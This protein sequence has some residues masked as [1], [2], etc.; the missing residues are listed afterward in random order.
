M[1]HHRGA[2]GAGLLLLLLLCV[3]AASLP[4]PISASSSRHDFVVVGSGSAGS[5]VAGRLAA[6]GHSVLLLEAGRRTQASLGGCDAGGDDRQATDCPYV[7]PPYVPPP[8]TPNT[9]CANPLS[10]FDV[11]LGWMEIITQPRFTSNF[12]WNFSRA[13]PNTSLPALARA[14]GG[15]GIHNAMI[16]VR[17]TETDFGAGSLWDAQGW[18][19]GTVLPFYRRTENN[20]DFPDSNPFHSTRGPVQI[21]SVATQDRAAVSLLF[22]RA[23]LASGHPYNPDF[24]GANRHGV[25]PYQFLIRNGVRDSSAAAFIGRHDGQT[26][27][28]VD[29]AP[30]ATVSRVL[31]AADDNGSRIGGGGGGRDNATAI[32]VE[33]TDANGTTRV[34]QATHEVI[35]SAGALGTP[36][37]LMRS[38]VGNHTDLLQAGVPR[39]VGA[40]LPAVGQGLMDGVYII[41]QF[42]IP[43][44]A[45]DAWERC[46]PFAVDTPQSAFCRNQSRLYDACN[47]SAERHGAYATPGLS[48]G[49]FLQSPYSQDKGPDVQVTFHPWDKFQ[50]NWTRGPAAAREAL[51]T[52]GRGRIVTLE[53][54]NLHPRST[55]SVRLGPGG[56]RDPRVPAVVDTPY[57]K[58]RADAEALIWGLREIR[59]ILTGDTMRGVEL[60]PG[61]QLTT[62]AE[63]VDYIECGAPEFR[64]EGPDA[65]DTSLMTVLHFGG[66]ARIG[67]VVDA[68]LRVRGI[69]RLRVAD[70]SVMPQLP[71]GNTHATTMMVAERAA[72]M[73]LDS[74]HGK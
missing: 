32:G 38:G 11:P 21:S 62:D 27:S 61:A 72:Q 4:A 55:G 48:T 5:V 12:E 46:S 50:R 65:C 33:Y 45:D 17:G 51:R 16:Y 6:A 36:A 63:L 18:D 69:A 34:A 68:E 24:N 43:A 58:D 53:I 70:A 26:V 73:I 31:F 66:T 52:Q 67:A 39:V 8:S 30:Q 22:E 47:S 49:L 7:P 56:G 35:L 41:A 74:T 57:M 15:C 23:A 71:S 44:A 42:L 60:L 1:H 19:W 10:V 40:P 2:A 37:V 20:T 3:C 9:T 54:G 25:G 28:R 13:L 29:L 64:P 14:V 59:E